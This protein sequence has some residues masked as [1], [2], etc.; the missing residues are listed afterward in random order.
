MKESIRKLKIAFSMLMATFLFGIVGYT[1]LENMTVFEA[2]YMT[3][4]TISTVGFMELH[5]LTIAGRIVTIIIITTGISIGAYSIGTLLR[6]II[7]GELKKSLGIRR[8]EKEI[9]KLRDHYIICGFGRIGRMICD[10]LHNHGKKFVVIENSADM[11]E[12]L[13]SSGYL[14]LI[15]DATSD[16][17]L[18][19]A[20]IMEA[21]GL[22]TAVRSDADNVFITLTARGFRPEIYVLSRSSDVK[23]EIK[24]RRA[25]ASRVVSPYL[26]G[27]KRM[28]QVLLRP[29]VVDFIDT[30]VM[31]SR[32]GLH[33][34]E[35]LVQVG[36]PL[37]GKNL[38]ESNLRRDYGA[39][40]VMIKKHNGDMKFNPEPDETI[41]EKDVLV[42]VGKSDRLVELENVLAHP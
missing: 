6:M 12:E 4:I 10:D 1:T 28:A 32:L 17:A 38:R 20:G 26:I 36:S 16:E 3:V 33:M 5:T 24:L 11:A 37:A 39:I 35:F 23:N 29:T 18:E 15:D 25:G 8:L 42:M 19:K 34:E 40:I 27:G 7:E 13:D 14:Y 31:E 22:V 30:A 41:E 9:A 2:F 21:R